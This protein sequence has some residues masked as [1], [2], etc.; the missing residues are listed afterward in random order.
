MSWQ[1]ER[2]LG[3]VLALAVV[4]A[5]ATGGWRLNRPF[6]NSSAV[7]VQALAQT[8]IVIDARGTLGYG[9]GHIPGALRLWSRDLLSYSGAVTGVLAA[10]DD[11]A[12]RVAA[13]G[14]TPGAEAVV[15]DGGNGADAPLVAMVLTAMGVEAR[16]LAGGYAG[17]VAAGGEP[18]Q[19]PVPVGIEASPGD[20]VL[21]LAVLV[22][23]NNVVAEIER[24]Q[25]VTVDARMG[26]DFAAGRLE[27]A[28]NLPAAAVAP[29]G[30][31][32]RWSGMDWLV[33]PAGIGAETPLMVYGDSVA[34]AAQV[35][36]AMRA[37]GAQS[38]QV[39]AGPYAALAAAGV[40][41]TSAQSA[42]APSRR[43]SI[44]WANNPGT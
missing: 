33:A 4:A 5:A 14:L 42:A 34:Q 32:Q 36:L 19:D 44:C 20:W 8:D 37:F 30:G 9:Q 1:P 43:P 11:I 16:V 12:R 35:W 38:V 31:L 24:T 23:L 10:T 41:M 6:P 18:T 15:Y 39:V 28:V 29:G 2:S 26:A 3:A 22:P 40:P 21:D 7:F 27:M 25:A 13:L 17:W